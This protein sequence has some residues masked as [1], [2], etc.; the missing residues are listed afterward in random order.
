ML[1]EIEKTTTTTES[2]EV[3]FP[4]FFKDEVCNQLFMFVGTDAGLEVTL[5]ESIKVSG[6]SEIYK[7]M[8]QL[9]KCI[10]KDYQPITQAEFARA[11]HTATLTF[12]SYFPETFKAE[13]NAISY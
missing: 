13:L 5:F 11:L 8:E 7:P 2:R 6:I 3:K 4:C 9:Q 10:N 12:E 1:I